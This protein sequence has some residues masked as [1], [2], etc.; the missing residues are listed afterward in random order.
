MVIH[1]WGSD[2]TFSLKVQGGVFLSYHSFPP[3]NN[4]AMGKAG[5]R[6]G[7]DPVTQEAMWSNKTLILGFLG[8]CGLHLV[9]QLMEHQL[10]CH[11]SKSLVGPEKKE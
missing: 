11:E 2:L 1:L 8:V 3:P 5:Q 4:S 10:S 6:E 7:T 9:K